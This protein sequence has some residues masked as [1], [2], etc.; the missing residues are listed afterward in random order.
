MRKCTVCSAV[1]QD[2]CSYCPADG[3][4]LIVSQD[5]QP[6]ISFPA[7]QN[8]PQSVAKR[9][10]PIFVWVLVGFGALFFLSLPLVLLIAIPTIGS[11]KKHAN[12]A[13]AM[14]SIRAIQTAE[15]TYSVNYPTSGYV[16]SLA[17]LGGDSSAGAPSATAAQLLKA[18]LTSGFKDGYIFA[19]TNCNKVNVSGA[20]RITSYTVTAVP[21]RVGRSGNRGFCTD[22]SGVIKVDPEGGSNCTQVVQ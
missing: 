5:Q 12:E 4:A 22:E 13:S 8:L 19:I 7:S 17:S 16:C 14:Q 9:R 18:N 10:I 21:Q 1:Y 15:M 2:E 6:S 11:V 20:D 3:A